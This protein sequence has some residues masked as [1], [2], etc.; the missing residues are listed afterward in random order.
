METIIPRSG[1]ISSQKPVKFQALLTYTKTITSKQFPIFV[2]NILEL[3]GGCHRGLIRPAA[4]RFSIAWNAQ[5]FFVF[6]LPATD[7]CL[8]GGPFS[9]NHWLLAIGLFL[10]TIGHCHNRAR[11]RH[12]IC[13]FLLLGL[14]RF[15]RRFLSPVSPGKNS[16]QGCL[17]KVKLKL[18][19]NRA[20]ARFFRPPG[21][22]V[23]PESPNQR[24]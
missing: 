5:H 4:A 7:P 9:K 18:H 16:E 6:F 13:F 11:Q 20:S 12:C 19:G 23:D 21:M 8:D 22:D 17:L 24:G 1:W 10:Q 3:Q 14:G 2:G 15:R